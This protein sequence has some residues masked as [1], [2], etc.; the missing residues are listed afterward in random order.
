MHVQGSCGSTKVEV[1]IEV[2]NDVSDFY[3]LIIEDADGKPIWDRRGFFA[4]GGITVLD[5]D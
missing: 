3:V 4:S 2:V 5:R 1:E